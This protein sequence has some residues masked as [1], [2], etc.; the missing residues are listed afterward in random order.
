MS[1]VPYTGK[2]RGRSAELILSTPESSTSKKKKTLNDSY[3][4]RNTHVIIRGPTIVPDS[5]SVKLIY[6]DTQGLT[7]TSG[8]LAKYQYRGNSL[9]DPDFTGTGNQPVGFDELMLLYNKFRVMGSK[10]TVRATVGATTQ[11]DDLV[12]LPTVTSTLTGVSNDTIA[13]QP[14]AKR[15]IGKFGFIT[16]TITQ[17]TSTGAMYGQSK[18]AVRSE[19]DFAGDASN[20]PNN[21]WFWSISYQP[22]DRTS[23]QAIYFS[24]KIEYYCTFYERKVLTQS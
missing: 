1:L 8:A 21:V 7:S 2:K 3:K 4:N 15:R 24:C 11:T 16:P 22:V 18:Q 17:Y 6:S 14:F 13:E 20:N 12:V 23:N 10:I 9:Y 5:Y 19:D